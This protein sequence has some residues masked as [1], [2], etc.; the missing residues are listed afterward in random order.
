MYGSACA[1]SG[2]LGSHAR[3][4]L[5][6][7]LGGHGAHRQRSALLPDV[8]QIIQSVQI[9]Q[10][11]RLHHPEVHSRNQALTPGQ[12]F[13]PLAVLGQCR[14]GL[15]DHSGGLILKGSRLHERIL[16]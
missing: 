1:S 5:Q 8:A 11:G 15:L 12:Q 4:A 3:I 9:H 6:L 14:E 10:Q 2:T 13:G 7:T 16:C